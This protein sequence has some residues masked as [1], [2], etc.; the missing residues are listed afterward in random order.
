M[1]PIESA[2]WVLVAA[3]AGVCEE[4]VYR[5]YL[6]PQLWSLNRSLPAAILLQALIFAAAHLYQ[7]WRPT[8]VTAIYGLG[9]GLLAAWRRSIVPGAI[10]HA[11]IDML[12]GLLRP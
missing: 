5:S 4:L 9:F 10:A 8:L 12:G 6:Q 3:I 1:G 2:A 11:L 7:G